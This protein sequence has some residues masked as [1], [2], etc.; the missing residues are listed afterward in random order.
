[1]AEDQQT[2]T[3]ST[4]PEFLQVSCNEKRDQ[5]LFM[6]SLKAPQYRSETRAPLDVIAVIDES[7]SMGGEKINLC[8]ETLE[9][10]IQ[11]LEESD[12][13]GIV[14]YSSKVT[15]RL[16][17][18][19]M[20]RD[21][22]EK[23]KHTVHLIH[24]GGGTSL[25]QG[26]EKGVEVI[27]RRKPEGK[28]EVASILLLTDGQTTS[29]PRD[30]DGMLQELRFPFEDAPALGS[31]HMSPFGK[32]PMVQQM[33]STESEENTILQMP[34]QYNPLPRSQPRNHHQGRLVRVRSAIEHP[35]PCSIN[36]FG[37]GA[38]HDP[39]LLK[40]LADAATGVYYYVA[41]NKDIPEA[42][43]DCLGGLVSV[44]A[45]NISVKIRA[46]NGAKISQIFTKFKKTE[47]VPETEFE[48]S[49]GDIQ[50]EEQRDIVMAMQLPELP[51]ED[52]QW[53]YASVELSYFNVLTC[54]MESV[55]CQAQLERQT[56]TSSSRNFQLDKHYNRLYAADAMSRVSFDDDDV[57][58][59]RLR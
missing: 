41:K 10:V 11:Q 55:T 59:C 56:S 20:T 30:V 15:E 23:A 9:F 5:F 3:L 49:L 14:S 19:K 4:T 17:L 31:D 51:S 50:S 44:T 43:A 2:I 57:M 26:L 29:V 42:F 28:N 25:Y 39:N 18:T 38:D 21:N 52:V 32:L 45:Q 12:R 36:T 46:E 54:M 22:K 16:P 37:Y 6:A 34:T 33:P 1:M 35:I 7:G 24:A 47:I 13:L 40:G 58:G 27:R 48:L 8:K 53:V